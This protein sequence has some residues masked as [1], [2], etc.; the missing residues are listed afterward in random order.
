MRILHHF[1]ADSALTFSTRPSCAINVRH[2]SSSPVRRCCQRGVD[3]AAAC[4]GVSTAA[5]FR[6]HPGVVLTSGGMK[7]WEHAVLRYMQD[8]YGTVTL[9]LAQ[10]LAYIDGSVNLDQSQAS[11]PVVRQ[12]DVLGQQGWQLVSVQLG[13]D[14]TEYW[15]K[16]PTPTESETG[17]A[18]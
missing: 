14:I 18:T 2:P 11:E 10:G 15:L 3:A 9:S 12:L 17:T 5:H 13:A 16:R 6:G 8:R 7:M 4:Y 1:P